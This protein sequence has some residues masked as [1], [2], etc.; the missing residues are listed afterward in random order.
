MDLSPGT[1]LVIAVL[2]I[3]ALGWVI[4]YCIGFFGFLIYSV[5]RHVATIL[6]KQMPRAE[7]LLL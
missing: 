2:G 4:G 3:I 1:W 7:V 5:V 6:E